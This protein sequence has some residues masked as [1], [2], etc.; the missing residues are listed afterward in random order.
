MY[1]TNTSGARFAI[2]AL[3]EGSSQHTGRR[4]RFQ[5]EARGIKHHW[6]SGIHIVFMQV[7]PCRCCIT[8]QHVSRYLFN[9]Y[10][11]FI[12]FCSYDD[13]V[14][15]VSKHHC[16]IV[17]TGMFSSFSLK[18]SLSVGGIFI[19]SIIQCHLFSTDK[20]FLRLIYSKWSQTGFMLRPP[21]IAS[22]L[23][24]WW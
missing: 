6:Y 21:F 13:H 3:S 7:F 16:E 12:K 9:K 19:S 1:F 23:L 15:Q 17:A 2:W 22:H 10:L 8:C 5:E 14:Q 18:R 24:L 20:I 11:Y 4:R